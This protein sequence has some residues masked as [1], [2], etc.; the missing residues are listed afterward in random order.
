MWHCPGQGGLGGLEVDQEPELRVGG[1]WRGREARGCLRRALLT[2]GL[3]AGFLLVEHPRPEPSRSL[4]LGRTCKELRQPSAPRLRPQDRPLLALVVVRPRAGASPWQ[5]SRHC[6]L[7]LRG[8]G[9]TDQGRT[10]EAIKV[11]GSHG[12]GSPPFK[13]SALLYPPPEGETRGSMGPVSPPAL[14]GDQELL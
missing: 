1:R 9:R 8:V 4:F 10:Q 7:D 3:W 12:P 5:C 6:P 2:P 13:G 14:L 11:G